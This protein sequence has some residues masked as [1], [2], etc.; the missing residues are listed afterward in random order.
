VRK[1]NLFASSF[2]AGEAVARTWFREIVI[3]V[4]VLTLLITPLSPALN[5]LAADPLVLDGTES[6]WAKPELELAYTYGLTYS[7]VMKTFTKPITREEFCVIVVK[8]YSKLTGKTPTAGSS[9]FTDTTNP[10]IV[11]AYNLG[12]VQGTG[13]GKFSP[14]LSITR[15]EIAT[16]IYRALGK[17]VPPLKAVSQT[18]FPFAD[19]GKVAAWALEAME[20]AYQNAIMKGVSASAIDPLS[21]TTREQGIVLIKR[22]YEAFRTASGVKATLVMPT[23]RT[24]MLTE[25]ARYLASD[26]HG[27]LNAPLYDARLTLYAATGSAKP[28]NKPA[29]RLLIKSVSTYSRADNAA[30]IDSTGNRVR[31][32][33]YTL[34]R[35]APAKVVWQVSRVPFVGFSRNWQN[36]TGLVASGQVAG[37][38]GEF[39]V[40]FGAFA[41]KLG[42]SDTLQPLSMPIVRVSATAKTQQ[43]LYVR[44]VPVDSSGRCIGDPGEGIRVLYGS[45]LS[46]PPSS[47]APNVV[48]SAFQVWTPQRDL[49][50]TSGKEFPNTLEH[51]SE[52]GTSAEGT[53][54]HWFQF[55]GAD[56][57][58]TSVV[59]QVAAKP[60]SSSEN[61][62]APAGLVYSKTYTTLPISVLADYPNAVP[63]TFSQFAVAASTLKPGDSIPYY[64]R[65]VGLKTSTTPGTTSA[66]ISETVKVNYYKQQTIKIYQW[67]TVSVSS[68]T[69]TIQVVHYQPV[70]WEDPNWAHYYTV[71]RYPKWNELNFNITNGASTL[72]TYQYYAMNDPTMT[73]DRYEKEILWKWL[74]PGSHL[75]VWD[76]S[77]DKS[78]WAE[79]WDGIVSF[80]KSIIDVVAKVVNWASAA[81][82]AI[83]G[84]I[85]AF[86]ASNF[87]L[88]PDDWKGY[89]QL[90]LTMLADS[91]L[92]ALGIPPSLPNFDQL[93]NGGLDYL[94]K[95]GLAAAG[96]PADA[97]TDALLDTA[98]KAIKDKLADST[99]SASPNPLNAPFLHADPAKLYQPAYIDVKVTNPYPDKPSL[100]GY[101]N[102][103]TGWDWKETGITVDTTTWAELPLDQQYAAGLTY[104]GHFF[105]GLKKGY[106]YYPVKYCIYEPMRNIAIPSLKPGESTTVRVYLKEYVGK[107][108][109]FAP[110]GESVTWDDFTNLYWGNTGKADF[111]AWTSGFSLAPITPATSFDPATSTIYT[112]KYDHS[113]SSQTFQTVPKDPY[114]G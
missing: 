73:P 65:V 114:N 105:Y 30:L 4:L 108:Y 94:A 31:Y 78:W 3:V 60:F 24:I 15:Q 35:A 36:P 113:S 72:Y 110:Q 83:K 40:D 81:F 70:Q 51:L 71:Y 54:A 85:I 47:S 97:V 41:S 29:G 69:P 93:A 58:V 66:T 16:M 88:I 92:A 2:T 62:D 67:K 11:K 68:Y 42:S 43:V 38:A 76:K 111:T 53:S 109:P 91:G 26:W 13:A 37:T 59:F 95:E 64:L 112:Y 9:P 100:A 21:N 34:T 44:A 45:S 98:K 39:S 90:A 102:I 82:D 33:A 89:L 28:K 17:A 107:P 74:T 55:R 25:K 75:Q 56:A 32:F 99:N 23:G 7:T 104:A 6:A 86:I 103:D 84:G 57:A 46:I 19:K 52:V 87:P 79:L 96:V 61:W 20:F 27:L 63:V 50:P 10:E 77:E 18:N 48:S 1:R 14:S 106:P 8:L 22:T 49:E 101:L 12:I 80:F 5:V